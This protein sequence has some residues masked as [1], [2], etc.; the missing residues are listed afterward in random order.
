M[1]KKLKIEL[2]YFKNEVAHAETE[3]KVL[4]ALENPL[5]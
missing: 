4:R 5:Y 1:F 3:N 2:N